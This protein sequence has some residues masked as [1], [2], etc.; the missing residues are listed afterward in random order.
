[1]SRLTALMAASL[2]RVMMVA[3]TCDDL[4]HGCPDRLFGTEVVEG[5]L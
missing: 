5:G 2:A 1:M 4:N 3:F